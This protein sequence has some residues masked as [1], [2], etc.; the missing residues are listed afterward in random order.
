MFNVLA[1]KNKHSVFFDIIKYEC[2]LILFLETLSRPKKAKKYNYVKECKPIARQV[3]DKVERKKLRP[4]C[5]KVQK[6]VC[7]YAPVEQCKEENKQYCYKAE[8]VVI[9]KVCTAERVQTIDESFNY[10]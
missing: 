10:V 4:V 1:S 3:C 5:D 7:S 6:N 2:Y 9:E 8:K